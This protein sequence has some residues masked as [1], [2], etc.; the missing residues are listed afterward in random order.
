MAWWRRE[1]FAWLSIELTGSPDYRLVCSKV[2]LIFA[3]VL[4][5]AGISNT[6]YSA[7]SAST[8]PGETLD[9]CTRYH[10][11]EQGMDSG[12]Y[13]VQLA[14]LRAASL[15]LDA[16]LRL[17]IF[18]KALSSSDSRLR[19][20]G[21]RYVLGSRDT[22]DVVIESPIHPTPDQDK[23]YK[24][25][26]TMSITK[27]ALNEKTDEIKAIVQNRRVTGAIIRGGFELGWPY[28][29]LRFATGEEYTLR[30][31]LHCVYPN[32]EPVE[33]GASIELG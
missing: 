10:H 22:F 31:T 17:L 6:A 5:L 29:R 7:P 26:A 24:R 16:S 32:A 18:E 14:S 15:E 2:Q 12:D 23:L 11:L 33:L 28:C 4:A 27:L 30:G 21:L 8:C 19:T 13:V 20:A 25:Y 1:R 9:E 3:L